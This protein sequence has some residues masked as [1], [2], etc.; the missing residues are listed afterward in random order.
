MTF[1]F[2]DPGDE[3][4][5][6]SASLNTTAMVSLLPRSVV[7]EFWEQLDGE[8][9]L[10]AAIMGRLNVR[11]TYAT[12]MAGLGDVPTQDFTSFTKSRLHLD[13]WVDLMWTFRPSDDDWA[14]D[15]TFFSAQI[16]SNKYMLRP[17]WANGVK[18][19]VHWADVEK[20]LFPINEPREH[21]ALGELHIRTGVL[22]IYDSLPKYLR[23]QEW[24]TK[25]MPAK[26]EYV[27]P[28]YL[29]EQGVLQAK[30]VDV[31]GYQITWKDGEDAPHQSGVL[32]IAYRE[33]IVDYLWKYKLEYTGS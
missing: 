5:D 3:E 26:F 21:W 19:P 8:A 29:K 14:M 20:V 2:K 28:K 22:T 23:K 11:F 7:R 18:Y 13:V 9:R 25:T 4:K 1:V 15:G 31:D 33:R 16:M 12:Y 32:A 24:W 17:Y 10:H 6:V 30:G 27:L